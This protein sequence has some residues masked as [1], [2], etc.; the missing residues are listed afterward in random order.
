MLAFGLQI[1]LGVKLH[2]LRK[3]AAVIETYS[4][5]IENSGHT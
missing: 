4:C 2:K 5:A 3:I 1:P